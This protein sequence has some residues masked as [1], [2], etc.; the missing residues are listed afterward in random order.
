MRVKNSRERN[1]YSEKEK[2]R[3]RKIKNAR[4]EKVL[5]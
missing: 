5:Y 3:E 1:C 4:E 2:F